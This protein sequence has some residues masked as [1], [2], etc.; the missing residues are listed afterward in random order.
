MVIDKYDFLAECAT[1]YGHDTLRESSLRW[2]SLLALPGEVTLVSCAMLLEQLKNAQSLFVAYGTGPW[3]AMRHWVE[4][5]S[6]SGQQEL[7]LVLNDD[8]RG[9]VP[10]VSDE[11]DGSLAEVWN[12]CENTPLFATIMDT[13][14]DAWGV[15]PQILKEAEGWRH[16]ESRVWGRLVRP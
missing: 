3:T 8:R 12:S 6:V 4:S 10:Y 16:K 2:V 11:T 14:C 9:H 7:A 13:V 1:F 15:N 5:E